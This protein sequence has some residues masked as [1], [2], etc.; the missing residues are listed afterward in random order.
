M[1]M[2]WEIDFVIRGQG[3]SMVGDGFKVFH[4]FPGAKAS[5]QRMDPFLMLDYNPPWEIPPSNKPR[6]VDVHP[7]RGFETV[8]FV[9]SGEV[10]HADS[11]GNFGTIGPG[12]IQWMHAAS[13]ILHKEY[14]SE[15]FTREGGV[16]H[17]AQLWVNLP[18]HRKKDAAGYCSILRDQIPVSEARGGKLALVAGSLAE[19]DEG[20]LSFVNSSTIDQN[21]IHG[22]GPVCSPILAAIMDWD[23]SEYKPVLDIPSHF[24]LLALVMN[25]A[26]EGQHEGVMAGDLLVFQ[27]AGTHR[28]SREGD[29]PQGLGHSLLSL[30]A[31]PGTKVLLLAGEPLGEPIAAYGPFVMNS[32]DEIQE[33]F[34]D[35]RNGRFGTLA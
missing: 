19:D 6:G 10:S 11:S 27:P 18:S 22:P 33:A 35:Y 7:H 26:L 24:T 34:E 17:M 4:L 31:R 25:G 32:A 12:E 8:T 14:Q 5:M 3:L 30:E 1:A 2:N 15:Q 21:A 20:V 29:V 13:G 16:F 23:S 28:N 9:F